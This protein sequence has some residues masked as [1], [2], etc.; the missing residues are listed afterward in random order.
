M[1]AC[2]T[3]PG[4]SP[5]RAQTAAH[6]VTAGHQRRVLIGVLGH[7]P[8][9]PLLDRGIDPLRHTTILLDSKNRRRETRGGS[10]S[11]NALMESTIGIYKT[12]LIDLETAQKRTGCHEVER[13]TVDWVKWFNDE[14]L[15]SAIDYREPIEY[16]EI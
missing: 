8:Q 13:E 4:Q 14:R 3:H 6:L 7:H 10:R 16:E 9:R 5:C 12:E 15:H 1:S 11:V 2:T